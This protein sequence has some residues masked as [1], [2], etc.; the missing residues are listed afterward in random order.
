MTRP[1]RTPAPKRRASGPTIP[2]ERKSR[3]GSYLPEELRGSMRVR[4]P[5]ALAEELARRWGTEPA[6]AVVQAVKKAVDEP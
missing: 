1:K 4:V 2:E 3:S 6:E 5:R